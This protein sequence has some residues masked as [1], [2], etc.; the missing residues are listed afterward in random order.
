MIVPAYNE[1]R[2][3]GQTLSGMPSFVDCILVVNDGSDDRTGEIVEQARQKDSRILP[4]T[5]AQNQGL[6]QSLIDG[7]L[8]SRELKFDVTAVMDGDG[9]MAPED[10]AGVVA[11]VVAGV[12]DYSKG[13]RLFDP[14]VARHMPLYRLIGNAALTFLTKFATGYWP[15]VDPQCAYAA[16]SRRALGAIPIER[17][18][19]GY[20]YN[21]DI[22]NMLNIQNFRVANVPVKPVYGDEQSKIKLSRYVF[23]VSGLLVR[24]FFRR[25]IQKYVVRNF[26]P[27]CLSYFAGLLLFLGGSIPLAAR[28]IY[29]YFIARSGFPQTSML[30]LM[31]T[32]IASL[33]I[34]L[35]A[36]QYDLEDNRDVFVHPQELE[37]LSVGDDHAS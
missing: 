17:M 29:L 37:H 7:Y 8:K 1:E 5:H 6:G 15:L 22:L 23:S 16:I 21:A 32:T 33:Q 3:I 30:C 18:K 31:L 12:A 25:L 24:L 2:H 34:L 11:P 4:I 28:I 9:Q 13:N 26:N 19:K 10:L 20:G 36:V 14:D 35:S 27:V